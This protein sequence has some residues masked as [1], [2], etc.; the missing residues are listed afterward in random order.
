M[1]WVGW[2][3]SCGWLQ[4]MLAGYT[5]LIDVL[6]VVLQEALWRQ[7]CAGTSWKRTISYWVGLGRDKSIHFKNTPYKSRNKEGEHEIFHSQ[8]RCCGSETPSGGV[9]TFNWKWVCFLSEKLK[10]FNLYKGWDLNTSL[11]NKTRN[12]YITDINSIQIWPFK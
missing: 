4:L 12:M 7:N 6:C 3:M 9:S 2:C 11:W 10:M 5:V 8:V 1:L